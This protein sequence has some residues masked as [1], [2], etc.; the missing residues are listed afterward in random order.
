M[1]ILAHMLS[2]IH[3]HDRLTENRLH[4]T[5][6]Q[7]SHNYIKLIVVFIVAITLFKPQHS[8]AQCD[9]SLKRAAYKGIET[10]TYLRDF[11]IS[12]PDSKAKKPV[13]EEKNVILNKGNRYRFS[14]SADPTLVG[15]PVVKIFDPSVE[16]ITAEN[17]TQSVIFDFVC[18][19]T[20]VY[21]VSV[22]FQN[23]QEGCCIL[24]LALMN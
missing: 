1:Q 19:K 12:L 20:Q 2:H 16:Y 9:N 18:N 3:T 21:Y 8:H 11:R 5:A 7:K 13:T 17:G 15:K 22:S 4:C 14:V 10:G 24:M 23:G 6:N